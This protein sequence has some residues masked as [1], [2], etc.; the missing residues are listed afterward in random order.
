MLSALEA[1][2]APDYSTTLNDQSR[3]LRERLAK[4]GRAV[5]ADDPGDTEKLAVDRPAG[6]VPRSF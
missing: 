2:P 4:F 1:D 6:W 5:A 3:P